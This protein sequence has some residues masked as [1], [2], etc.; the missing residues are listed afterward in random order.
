MTTPVKIIEVLRQQIALSLLP[1]RN[2]KD[3]PAAAEVRKKSAD[4]TIQA[5]GKKKQLEAIEGGLKGLKAG[6]QVTI[7]AEKKDDKDLVTKIVVAAKP[8][9]K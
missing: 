2:V 9:V 8:K 1:E 4:A 6:D 5:P 7:T 3:S